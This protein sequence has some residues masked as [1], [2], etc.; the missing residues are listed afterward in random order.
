MKTSKGIG[1]SK[2]FRALREFLANNGCQDPQAAMEPLKPFFVIAESGQWR[3][4]L[5]PVEEI[6]KASLASTVSA[7]T[8]EANQQGCLCFSEPAIC[9][10]GLDG[11]RDL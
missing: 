1:Q 6:D 7:L 4:E 3:P 5:S 8:V 11:S 9:E 10:A 2:K